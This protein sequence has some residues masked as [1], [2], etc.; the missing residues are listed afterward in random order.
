MHLGPAPH[1]IIQN[2]AFIS[3]SL[4]TATRTILPN[5]VMCTGCSSWGLDPALGA[6]SA[7]LSQSEWSRS[8][9]F[10]CLWPPWTV[11][12]QASPSMGFS[13]QGYW[14]GLPFPSPADLPYPGI[15]P[16][17]PA[18]QADAL[19]SEPP[20]KPLITRSPQS[21]AGLLSTSRRVSLSAKRRKEKSKKGASP[22]W[23]SSH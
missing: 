4:T 1:G 11:A 16:R 2:N 20:G 8:V 6:V 19:P 13:R 23:V 14:S 7:L 10:D 9:V 15:E 5:E 17:S 21:P 18:L 22:S 12:Y 3:E